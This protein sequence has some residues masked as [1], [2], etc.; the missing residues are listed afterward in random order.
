MAENIVQVA[1]GGTGPKLH[2]WDT[3]IGAN[4][5]HDEF[6]LPAEYPYPSYV[7]PFSN[8][9]VA[10][11]ADHV[12]ALNAGASLKVRVRR[13]RVE[14]GASATTAGLVRLSIVRT[15][16]AAPTGGSAVTPAAYDTADAAAGA[17]ARTLP[18]AKG[19]E[20]TTLFTGVI[21]LRQAV[22]TTGSPADDAIFEWVQMPNQKPIIIPT[23]STNGLVIKVGTGVAAAT[24]DGF[25]EFVETA[26]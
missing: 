25:I 9:S 19:T 10:T 12:C 11:S 15:T 22:S 18:T 23:G 16:T 24:V 13:I 1:T 21:I 3:T 17:S 7:V 20:T 14:Q 5:V 6:V 26:F 8:I 4:V 2:S